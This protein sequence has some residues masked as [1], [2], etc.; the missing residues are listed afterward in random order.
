MFPPDKRDV[1]TAIREKEGPYQSYAIEEKAPLP[2][3]RVGSYLTP[4]DP[5]N[6]HLLCLPSFTPE[7]IETRCLLTSISIRIYV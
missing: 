7:D 3:G 1:R 2:I 6:E 4:I 5:M